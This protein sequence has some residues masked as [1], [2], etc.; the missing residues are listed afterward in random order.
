MVTQKM[1]ASKQRANKR[2][3]A[4]EDNFTPVPIP[5]KPRA[6]SRESLMLTRIIELLGQFIAKDTSVTV[7]TPDL[8]KQPDPVVHV[9]VP[10]Q[11]K[12]SIII[13]TPEQKQQPAPIINVKVPEQRKQDPP[14]INVRN[15][16][17]KFPEIPI[18][19]KWFF[20]INRDDRGLITNITAERG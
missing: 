8:P 10:E 5:R 15:P 14:I 7:N 1:R 17:I 2:L 18:A 11:Q 16:D 4:Y 6:P 19:N 9:N 12:P 13:N 3:Q 20:V